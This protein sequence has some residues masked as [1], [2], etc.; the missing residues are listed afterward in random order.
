M[1]V[2]MIDNPNVE[3]EVDDTFDMD[4]KDPA[5]CGAVTS[6]LWEIV[7]LQDHVLP[8][9]SSVAKDLIEKGLREMELDFSSHL[10]TTYQE[11]FEK[12]TK[13]KIF[14]YVPVNWELPDGLKLAQDDIFS[15]II[16]V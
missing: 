6:S 16:A 5:K 7:S 2:K 9:V 13:K 15:Q 3:N 14:T 12:E 1:G 8:Q 10:E 11:M 4:E